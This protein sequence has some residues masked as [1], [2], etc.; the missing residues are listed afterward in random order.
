MNF[1]FDDITRLLSPDMRI[2][3]VEDVP[4]KLK[5]VFILAYY[6]DLKINMINI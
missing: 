6:P 1:A 5:S 3:D 2:L 4:I